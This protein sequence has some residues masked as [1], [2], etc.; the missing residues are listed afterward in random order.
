M[1]LAVALFFYVVTRHLGFLSS[2]NLKK[3]M[4]T[5]NA[6][7]HTRLIFAQL[8]LS[9]SLVNLKIYLVTLSKVLI[10]AYNTKALSVYSFITNNFEL[11]SSFQYKQ[12][13]FHSLSVI[14]INRNAT[15]SRLVCMLENG[16]FHSA[17]CFY[18]GGLT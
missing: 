16:N 17:L 9:N 12:M 8:M 10:A 7:L 13:C 14:V 15:Y 11:A 6:C 2:P 5:H 1:S 4:H 3:H 18:K